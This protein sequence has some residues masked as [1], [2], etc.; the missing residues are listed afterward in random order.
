M[1]DSLAQ[2]GIA[3]RR[4][5]MALPWFDRLQSPEVAKW[6][7]ESARAMFFE[8]LDRVPH[9]MNDIFGPWLQQCRDHAGFNSTDWGC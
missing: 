8:M 2:R 1:T 5:D 6:A 7:C 9:G 4:E 3:I